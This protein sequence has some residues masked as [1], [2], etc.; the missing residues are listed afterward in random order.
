M[1]INDQ[2]ELEQAITTAFA[3]PAGKTGSGD[4]FYA[5]FTAKINDLI[6]HNF[7][8]LITAL[9]RIDVNEAKLKSLLQDK[10]DT[11]AA[12]IIADLIIERQLQKIKS[13]REFQQPGNK[14]DNEE[15]W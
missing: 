11:D 2:Q 15:M 9:Y 10:P 3:L 12:K 5:A 14:I 7:N 8:F 1:E 6:N 4:A 13:R